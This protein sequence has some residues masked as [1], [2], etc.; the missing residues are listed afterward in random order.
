MLYSNI[1]LSVY[2]SKHNSIKLYSLNRELILLPVNTQSLYPTNY[3]FGLMIQV[4]MELHG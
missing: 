1:S 4:K 2:Q 3:I